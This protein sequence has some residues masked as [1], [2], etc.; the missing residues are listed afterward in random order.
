MA[1]CTAYAHEL[2]KHSVEVGLPNQ[3]AAFCA[4]LLLAH[5]LLSRIGM[6]KLVEV[7]GLEC[8]VGSTGGQPAGT[9]VCYLDAGL[10]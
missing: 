9:V 5:R 1:V 10:D 7:T 2:P 6:E 4:S 8:N 3:V